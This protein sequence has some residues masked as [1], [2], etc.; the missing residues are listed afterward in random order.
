[1]KMI[2]MSCLN[3][4]DHEFVYSIFDKCYECKTCRSQKQLEEDP[5]KFE[6]IAKSMLQYLQEMV[7]VCD[8]G[9]AIDPLVKWVMNLVYLWKKVKVK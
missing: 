9:D 8:V 2:K 1:M 3:G 6:E 5:E 7:N 4:K